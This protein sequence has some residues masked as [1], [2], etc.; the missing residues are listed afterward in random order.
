MLAQEPN[1]SGTRGSILLM[2]SVTATDPSPELFA[3][4]AYAA[5]KGAIDRP[6]DDDGRD[7]RDRTGS[8]STSSR[9][10]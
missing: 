7:L 10:R 8:G 1:G 9:R 4:H 5:A 6:D 2:G 3:T